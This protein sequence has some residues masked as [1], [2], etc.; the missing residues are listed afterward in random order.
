MVISV[1]T[2]NMSE[3]S[4][5]VDSY[6]IPFSSVEFNSAMANPMRR[7][8]YKYKCGSTKLYNQAFQN[9]RMRE[10]REIKLIISRI[11]EDFIRACAK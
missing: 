10:M 9:S 3:V 2:P 5:E 7:A 1:G 8:C 4:S 6:W 11:S